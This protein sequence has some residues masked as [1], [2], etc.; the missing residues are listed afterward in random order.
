MA[1]KYFFKISY[2]CSTYGTLSGYVI[3]ENEE[4]A[5]ERIENRDTEGE[6]YDDCDSDN[7]VYNN[8]D[9]QLNIEEEN[10][11]DPH[12]SHT[13]IWNKEVESSIP[14]YFLSEINK[15]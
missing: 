15:I 4:E 3:A 1:N 12:V 2:S 14:A 6:E 9:L 7:Y 10:V 5:F 13:S 11:I 8:E